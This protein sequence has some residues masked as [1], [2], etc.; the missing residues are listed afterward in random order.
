ML[1]FVVF[2]CVGHVLRLNCTVFR[3]TTCS[4]NRQLFMEQIVEFAFGNQYEETKIDINIVG[5]I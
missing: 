1:F 3:F 4:W 2:R 5:K